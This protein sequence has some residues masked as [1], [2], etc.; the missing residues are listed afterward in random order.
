MDR[1]ELESIWDSRMA[2]WKE[3]ALKSQ[4]TPI[5]MLCVGH[6]K[7]EGEGDIITV[8]DMTDDDIL[9]T[10]EAMV[11]LLKINIARKN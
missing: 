7:H 2:K 3:R 4:A 11:K 5:L 1:P 6:D 9:S 8:E 10:L